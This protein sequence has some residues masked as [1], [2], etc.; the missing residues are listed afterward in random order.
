M[1]P[2]QAGGWSWGACAQSQRTV[3]SARI[4]ALCFLAT[5]H[6]RGLATGRA[7]I[8]ART[9]LTLTPTLAR[10][11]VSVV[12]AAL[13]PGRWRRRCQS[14]LPGCYRTRPGSM[15]GRPLAESRLCG[16][17]RARKH[18][19]SRGMGVG[20]EPPTPD[21]HGGAKARRYGGRGEE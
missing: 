6:R 7:H 3:N 19:R 13:V 5:A 2:C 15:L 4:R 11:L 10:L 8:H 1:C 18:S 14:S 12:S 9:L 20:S 17:R 16:R 21:R